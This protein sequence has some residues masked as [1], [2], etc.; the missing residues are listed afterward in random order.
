MSNVKK[1]ILI[2]AF[3]P[4]GRDSINSSQLV[5]ESLQLSDLN[6]KNNSKMKLKSS[7][8]QS[9]SRLNLNEATFQ[10]ILLPVYYQRSFDQLKKQTQWDEL[11]DIIM[12]GQAG[13]RKSICL[14]RLAVNWQESL[15]A[16]EKGV[17]KTGKRISKNSADFFITPYPL[18]EWMENLKS[19][20]IP[21]EI[22]TSAGTFVCNDLSYRVALDVYKMNSKKRWL[23]IHLPYVPEQVESKAV[24]SLKLTDMSRVL[25]KIISWTL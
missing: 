7:K 8:A 16:D 18:L 3:E 25:E 13:G 5:L 22:S 11:T 19:E 6:K 2:T 12:L 23:F 1:N 17:V 4:F 21:V 24:A 10:K 14:E 15:S 20:T 9:R